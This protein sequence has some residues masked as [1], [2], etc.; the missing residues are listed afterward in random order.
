VEEE[1]PDRPD[2]PRYRGN[3]DG[4]SPAQV[5]VFDNGAVAILDEQDLEA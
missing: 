3:P 4:S 5:L 1:R 2:R